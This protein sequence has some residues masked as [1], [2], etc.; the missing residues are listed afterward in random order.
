MSS[1]G[2]LG[3]HVSSSFVCFH[4]G[5]SI[6]VTS[7]FEMLCQFAFFLSLITL[8]IV[9]ITTTTTIYLVTKDNMVCPANSS[10]ANPGCGYS[11]RETFSQQICF[12]AV[13]L[14]VVGKLH[15]WD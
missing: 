3:Y 1:L 10:E 12:Q 8:S 5:S 6:F 4:N 2:L 14:G 7:V 13:P 15:D 11:F 9:A